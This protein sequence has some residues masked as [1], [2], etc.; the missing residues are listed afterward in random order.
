MRFKPGPESYTARGRREAGGRR[1]H[2]TALY[3]TVERRWKL[4]RSLV[5][6]ISP[7][8][9]N[10]H[11]SPALVYLVLECCLNELLLIF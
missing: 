2:S 1:Q 8:E 4:Y 6:Y 5:D 9:F 3:C 7:V 10:T 11:G